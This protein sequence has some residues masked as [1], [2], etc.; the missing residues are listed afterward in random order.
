MQLHRRAALLAAA[1][2]G[3]LAIAGA[4]TW[5]ADAADAGH[6][7]TTSVGS[8]F[9]GSAFG[10]SA[11]G[12]SAFGGSASVGSTSGGSVST[13]GQWVMG[14][15]VG[16]Q[17]SRY[18]IA[19]I[20]WS[21][22]THVAF[23]PMT[24]NSDLSLNLS[25]DDQYGTGPADAKALAKAAH[26]HGAKALLMLGG[27]GA[28]ANIAT[29][30]T[31]ANRPAFVKRLLAA[32]DQ[33]GYDGLDLDWEDAVTTQNLIALAR[34]LRAARPKLLL[35]YPADVINP[36]WQT[37]DKNLA[38][39]AGY[40]D[41][42]SIM[43]YHPATAMIGSG[44]SSWFSSPLTG[45][46]PSTPIAIDDSLRRWAAVGVPKSK[47]LMGIGGYAICYPPGITKPRQPTSTGSITGGDNDF[48]L[49]D[50]FAKGGAL[51]RYPKARIWD[52]TSLQPYLTLPA[53]A[54]SD[55]HCH[56]SSR[57]IPYDDEQ[58]IDSKGKFSKANGY[59][60]AIVWTIQQLWLPKS[61]SGG[62]PQ[63]F[64]MAAL[65]HSFLT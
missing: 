1:L 48:P 60:G 12:G 15:Y 27:A 38:T 59:G 65:H 37:P 34:D 50:V 4:G 44:W 58:S 13:T 26:G 5:S 28:G 39:L 3:T 18:P 32:T 17:I 16:Y 42:F 19:A 22:M 31:A 63:N 29:A 2:A 36:N 51:D 7:L 20:D 54:T 25:F 53:G 11:F 35:T 49:G 10:G 52:R 21:G 41:K 30:A 46:A 45:S 43:S 64:L 57:Y 47:L 6:P 56:Q 40:V 14:Y 61:A 62:R 24:V 55:A 8:A 9:G 23:G 33:L